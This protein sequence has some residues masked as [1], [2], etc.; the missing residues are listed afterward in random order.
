MEHEIQERGSQLAR[1]DTA[2]HPCL[3]PHVCLV[4]PILYTRNPPETA[5]ASALG[6]FEWFIDKHTRR[7]AWEIGSGTPPLEFE[8]ENAAAWVGVGVDMRS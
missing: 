6:F 5:N 4:P 2:R 8:V 3:V 1:L 7:E